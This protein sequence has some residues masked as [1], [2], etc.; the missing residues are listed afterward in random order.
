MR[1]SAT[2][3]SRSPSRDRSTSRSARA[4]GGCRRSRASS[5]A[6][7]RYQWLID[8]GRAARRAAGS[9]S[10]PARLRRGIDF[11][12]V[13]FRYPGTE[14]PVL[15]DVDLHLPAGST[16]AVVG[17]NGAGKTTVVKLLCR[18]Y[19]PTE[20]QITVDGVD[21]A[22]IEPHAWRRQVSGAFQD[23]VRFELLLR[24][25]VGIGE[26]DRLDDPGAVDTA[27][28][29]PRATT[30]S[31]RCRRASRHSSAARTRTGG[32]SRAVS[33]RSSRS[34]VG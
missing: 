19:E 22:E 15:R 9:A 17:E 28:E 24:E 23:F 1:P 5:R 3:C 13:S 33:G 29:G 12:G 18:F 6:L 21:L 7:K 4:P 30:S 16:V 10:P 2:C 8:Y 32:T 31:P 27:L 14:V 34:R 26:L 11:E 25:T 20:G